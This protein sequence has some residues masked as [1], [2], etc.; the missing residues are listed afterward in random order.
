MANN[1]SAASTKPAIARPFKGLLKPLDPY[2]I[3]KMKAGKD[4]KGRGRAS[5]SPPI[6]RQKE[7]IPYLPGFFLLMPKCSGKGDKLC[8]SLVSAIG[9]FVV[10]ADLKG[11]AASAL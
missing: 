5:R 2:I 8:F 4:R 10:L 3:A 11:K 6:A 9:A 1:T 7:R